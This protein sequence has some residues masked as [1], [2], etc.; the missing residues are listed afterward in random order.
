MNFLEKRAQF[1]AA[2]ISEKKRG[3]WVGSSALDLSEKC[4]LQFGAAG[5]LEGDL[6][7]GGLSSSAA[8]IIA[9]LS[10]LCEANDIHLTDWELIMV[11][12]RQRRMNMEASIAESW[13]SFARCSTERTNCCI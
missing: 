2:S 5:V 12:I 9:F 4:K 8:V 10:V 13:I 7:I 1:H 3:D 6:L 11:V